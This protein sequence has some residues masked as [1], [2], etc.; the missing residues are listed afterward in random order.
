MNQQEQHEKFSELLTLHQ[1][2]LHG[3][4]LAL[5]RNRADADDLFQTTSLVLWRSSTLFGRAAVSLLGRGGRR[6]SKSQLPEAESVALH[7][8]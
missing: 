7:P 6:N 1:G 2:Q 8:V 5:V 4:I 3:Y